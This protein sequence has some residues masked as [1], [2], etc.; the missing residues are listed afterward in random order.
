MRL[1]E[2]RID[3][4]RAPSDA[5]GRW[6]RDG[7][8]LEP[9]DG[10]HAVRR[11]QRHER[12]RKGVITIHGILKQA[13]RQQVVLLAALPVGMDPAQ[14]QVVRVIALG[15]FAIEPAAGTRGQRTPNAVVHDGAREIV[16]ELEE[17]RGPAFVCRAPDHRPT[18]HIHEAHVRFQDV[19]P[20]RDDSGEHRIHAEPAPGRCRITLTTLEVEAGAAGSHLEVRHVGEP[21]SQAVC[22]AVAQVLNVRVVVRILER[23]HRQSAHVGPAAQARHPKAPATDNAAAPPSHIARRRVRRTGGRWRRASSRN[24]RRACAIS[25]VRAKRSAGR[26][27]RQRSTMVRSPGATPAGN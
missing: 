2:I 13:P 21:A 20:S 1:R 9:I 17:I 23:Q 16:L 25:P 10:H 26:F 24:S 11:C 5:I 19:G 4:E 6:P 3:V 15:R 14:E 18:R 7:G 12:Q 22:N 27:A 8:P